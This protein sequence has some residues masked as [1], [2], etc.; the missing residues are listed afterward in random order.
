[1]LEKYRENTSMKRFLSMIA[2]LV[3]CTSMTACAMTG[4]PSGNQG[5][6]IDPYSEPIIVVNENE[7][8]RQNRYDAEGNH[9]GYYQFTSGTN[10]DVYG[11]VLVEYLDLE[12][13]ALKKFSP[14]FAG[15][16]MGY[17]IAEENETPHELT[18]I[19]EVSHVGVTSI[20]YTMVPYSCGK[21]E[22][23]VYTVNGI[24]NQ[25]DVYGIDGELLRSM[26]TSKEKNSFDVTTW[27]DDYIHVREYYVDD[28]YHSYGEKE[29]FFD[30][31]RNLLCEVLL[32]SEKQKG[33]NNV[34]VTRMEVKGTDGQT[35]RIYEPS[36]EGAYFDIG[37]YKDDKQLFVYENDKT[38]E[39]IMQEIYNPEEDFVIYREQV[40]YDGNGNAS[41]KEF[42]AY[43]GKV[44]T[45]DSQYKGYYK[46]IEFYDAQGVLKYTVD[47]T[48]TREY[49]TLRWDKVNNRCMMEF[50][51]EQGPTGGYDFY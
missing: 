25:V 24:T 21:M 7:V 39:W 45:T 42:E 41:H 46:K 13:N 5:E 47:M 20:E 35:K 30:A 33:S 28:T 12:G 43:G 2:I 8:E 34:H 9:V 4:T 37:G 49:I 16:T 48:E 6:K 31:N 15:C 22:K 44:V 17:S 51:T 27:A 50:Y 40:I 1:M 38:G 26:K 23:A 18:T 3:L 32:T 19:C 29:F 36:V 11:I 14:Q 10:C